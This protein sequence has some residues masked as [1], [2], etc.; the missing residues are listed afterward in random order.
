MR[1]EPEIVRQFVKERLESGEDQLPNPL[2]DHLKDI[3][4]LKASHG[5]VAE[6]NLAGDLEFCLH[7]RVE[8]S[9]GH[10]RDY[11]AVVYRRVGL[12]VVPPAIGM[13]KRGCASGTK[14]G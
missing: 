6:R 10:R 3:E 13:R 9:N 8:E 7:L 5:G 4:Y 2:T 14:C 12:G 11:R 1:T